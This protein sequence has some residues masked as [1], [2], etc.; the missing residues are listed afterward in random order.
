LRIPPVRPEFSIEFPIGSVAAVAVRGTS[1]ERMA[2][3]AEVVA[4]H[5]LRVL[6]VALREEMGIHD[7]QLR[8]RL[9]TA[10]AFDGRVAGWTQREDTAY[11]LEVGGDLVERAL[12]RPVARMPAE[13]TNDLQRKANLAL[14]WM[15]R[16]WFATEPL[17]A[18]LYLFFALEAL[19]GDKSE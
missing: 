7:R 1:H 14:R 15:E 9:G 4:S 12:A 10:Y 8:F 13:P 5:A 19:L 18:L 11:E 3:R 2:Q 17:V 6:R 16:A